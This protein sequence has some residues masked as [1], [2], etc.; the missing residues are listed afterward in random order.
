VNQFPEQVNYPIYIFD[1][2][3]IENKEVF[4]IFSAVAEIL[5]IRNPYGILGFFGILDFLGVFY[6]LTLKWNP[7][8]LYGFRIPRKSDRS[9]FSI[10]FVVTPEDQSMINSVRK[11]TSRMIKFAALVVV[12]A[13]IQLVEDFT[14]NYTNLMNILIIFVDDIFKNSE[15]ILEY[16]MDIIWSILLLGCNLADKTSLVP[17]FVDIECPKL[18]VKWLITAFKCKGKAKRLIKPIME[19]MYN[20]SRHKDGLKGLEDNKAFETLMEYKSYIS[21][22]GT[23]TLID[24]FSMLLILLCTSDNDQNQNQDLILPASVNLLLSVK[25]AYAKDDWRH[26]GCHLSEY[27]YCLR[28]AFSNESVIKHVFDSSESDVK[29]FADFLCSTYGIMF[30]QNADDLEKLVI[31]SLLEIIL[32]LS[33]IETYRRELLSHST[34]YIFIQSLSKQQG[35]DVAKRIW[36]NFEIEEKKIKPSD[37]TVKQNAEGI[38][39]SYNWAN[40]SFCKKFVEELREVIAIPVWV[41]DES[42][43]QVQ[44]T[45]ESIASSINS[46]TIMIVL[47]STAYGQS[48]SNHLELV[49]ACSII[50]KES[51]IAVE[52]ESN[53]TFN[54]SWLEVRLAD[55]KKYPYIED[56]KSFVDG[57]VN[58]ND[59]LA[60]YRKPTSTLN[61]SD[62]SIQSSV[63][64]IA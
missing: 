41:H 31:E 33:N 32:S 27:L 50:G 45:W 64:T 30:N 23:K 5:G 29:F 48:A 14:T 17:I 7:W 39:I 51:I 10:D 22:V 60:K 43:S 42:T 18:T 55:F 44:D 3:L 54:R 35:H 26:N 28:L 25:L 56:P 2:I 62:K 8:I 24:M 11:L 4:K 19:N 21:D 15:N 61:Q 9:Q 52:A 49:Y 40:R 1:N 6:T 16:N 63:C 34:L 46:A 13:N 59:T 38:F 58:N 57:I 20:I 47:V 53:F 12:H 37:T 36:T